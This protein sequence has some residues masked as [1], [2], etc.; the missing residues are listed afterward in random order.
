MNNRAGEIPKEKGKCMEDDCQKKFVTEKDLARHADLVH[1]K[2]G[3]FSSK[4]DSCQVKFRYKEDIKGHVD[5]VHLK[6]RPFSCKEDGCEQKF[7]QGGD[8]ETGVNKKPKKS[9][10]SGMDFEEF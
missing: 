2:T 8:L 3:P 4:E 6:K 7:G 10:L 9:K 1:L 5:E